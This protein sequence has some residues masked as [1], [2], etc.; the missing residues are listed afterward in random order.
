MPNNLSRSPVECCR[1]TK[2]SQAAKPRPFSM[3]APFPIAAIIA[4]GIN[5]SNSGKG[6]RRLAKEHSLV[7]AAAKHGVGD[8]TRSKFSTP[9]LSPPALGFHLWAATESGQAN[10][11]NRPTAQ[12]RDTRGCGSVSTRARTAVGRQWST[13]IAPS[14]SV[15]SSSTRSA[16]ES[17]NLPGPSSMKH[18]PSK[19]GPGREYCFVNRRM[20][21]SAFVARSL[22]VSRDAEKSSIVW[23]MIAILISQGIS[24]ANAHS[25]HIETTEYPTYCNN[26]S[27]DD[28]TL[29]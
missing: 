2:P 9:F 21:M 11:R 15:F 12:G 18:A 24:P 7:R 25:E 13:C 29:S 17:R 23:P 16:T 8:G 5:G 10:R 20:R 27:R 19:P 26:I 14:F 6:K 4:V 22:A 3:S 28:L 1:S